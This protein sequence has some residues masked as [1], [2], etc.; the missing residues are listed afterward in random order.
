[1]TT[2]EKIKLIKI[3]KRRERRKLKEE[4]KYFLL[5]LCM[6]IAGILLFIHQIPC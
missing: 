5:M 1:M 2:Y 4:K 6:T 3:K